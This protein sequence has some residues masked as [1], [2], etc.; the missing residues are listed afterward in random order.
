[1]TVAMRRPASG[2]T[3]ERVWCGRTPSEGLEAQ[4]RARGL[5]THEDGGIGER[6][7]AGGITWDPEPGSKRG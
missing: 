6:G 7:V 4:V 5:L 2:S 3:R 1:M